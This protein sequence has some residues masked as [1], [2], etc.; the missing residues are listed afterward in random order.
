MK[1]SKMSSVAHCPPRRP[2]ALPSRMTSVCLLAAVLAL[3]GNAGAQVTATLTDFGLTAPTPGA[4]DQSQLTIPAGANSPDGLNYYFDNGTPPGQTFTTGSNPNGYVL[5][6][7]TIGTAGNGGSLPGAGQAYVLRLYSVSGST[8]TLLASYQSQN[9]FTFTET[10][11]LQWTNLTFGLQ[12]NTQYAYSFSRV[13]SGWENMANVANNTYTGGEVVLIPKGG[14]AMTLGA[15][16]NFDAAFDVGLNVATTLTVNPPVIAPQNAVTAGTAVTVGTAP[17]VGPG[18]ISYQWKTDGGSG[19]ALTNIPAATSATLSVNTAGMTVGSYQYAVVAN[20]GTSSVT[21]ATNALAIYTVGNCVLT[22]VGSVFNSGSYDISQLA[23]GSVTGSGLDGLNYYLDQNTPGQTF[24]TGTNTQ[25]YLFQSLTFGTGHGGTQGGGIGNL[26][27]YSVSLYSV[28]TN[29]SNATLMA[30]YT[31]AGFSIIVG[32]YTTVSGFPP[33]TL[34]PGHTYAFTVHRTTSGWCNMDGTSGTDLYAGGQA[35]MIA[36][37]GGLVT[38]GNSGTADAAFDVVATPIGVNVAPIANPI[39]VSPTAVT[40]AGAPLALT[41]AGTGSNLHFVWQTDGGNGGTLT[42]IPS[43]TASNLLVNTTGWNPGLYRY[44]VIVSN[45]YGAA[46]SAVSTVT[47]TLPAT[48]ADLMD[49]GSATPVPVSNDQYQTISS[50][51]FNNPDGLNYYTDNSSPPGQTFTTGNNPNGYLLTS[52]AIQTAGN[53]GQLPAAGQP[54]VLNIY[55]VSGASA[56]LYQSITSTATNFT[57]VETDWLRWSGLNVALAPNKT[58]GYS[59]GK[60]S[61]GSGW[62]NLGN[63]SGDPYAGG[64]VGLFPP[65]G[66]TIT[67]GSSGGF[68][69]VFVAGLA[70]T[71]NPIVTPAVFSPATTVYAGTP[72]KVSATVTGTGPFTYQ[73]QAQDASNLGTFTNVPGANATSF[74][75]DTTG[76]DV[77]PTLAYRLVVSNGA[78]STTGESS[79]LTVLPGSAPMIH[80][81]SDTTPISARPVYWRNCKLHRV[82]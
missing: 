48:K 2:L 10:D 11:W 50:G 55:T 78:G 3:A 28:N 24:T 46:T 30:S 20:N 71:G 42:N 5:S 77:V 63:V 40:T 62:E 15:S 26:Q 70:V 35:C 59:F 74:T 37:T 53:G 21:S 61:T 49:I 41:E 12:P 38:Y 29:T 1:I 6:S 34:L 14:G 80:V 67:F 44:V 64:Q 82:V 36:A 54:Y 33:L 25:G 16:H 47:I 72:V 32:D 8:A 52:L 31:N 51:G 7:L 39:N 22:D 58:Y 27:G 73:W 66:G 68:D 56:T 13:S 79:A 19:G 75:V 65:N 9:N 17:A 43:A 81:G 23:G 4:D 18:P 60:L 45:T 76:L 69:A 57:F